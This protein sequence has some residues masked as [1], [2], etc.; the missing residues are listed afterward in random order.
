MMDN[1]LAFASK[2]VDSD[3]QLS[4]DIID[5][6]RKH[7][8]R[9]K[10]SRKKVVLGEKIKAISKLVRF[11]RVIQEENENIVKL[12]ALSPSGKLPLGILSKG[13]AAIA[14]TL[15]EFHKAQIADKENMELPGCSKHSLI[16]AKS[17]LT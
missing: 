7:K 15:A 6:L 1:I 9:Q 17:F 3:G 8:L 11:Y 5:A 13:G 16:R 2:E 4:R 14:K 12:K 10:K